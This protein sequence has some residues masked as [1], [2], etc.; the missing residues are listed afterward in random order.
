ML[1][2]TQKPGFFFGFFAGDRYYEKIDKIAML[3]TFIKFRASLITDK[4]KSGSFHPQIICQVAQEIAHLRRIKPEWRWLIGHGSGSFGHVVAKK[5]GTIDGVFTAEQ[6][7]GFAEVSVMAKRLNHLVVE[8]LSEFTLPIFGVQPS[9][10]AL[11]ENGQIIKMETEPILTAL[12]HRLIPLVYGDVALDK[13]LESTII[14]TEKIFAYL[15]QDLKP[16]RIFLLG[17]VAGISDRT[18]QI[19]EKITPD[20][21]EAIAPELR[22]YN[23][24]DV[25]GG[26]ADKVAK[27]LD[28][29]QKLPNL[30]IRIFS[31]KVPGELEAAL[32]G[33]NNSGTLIRRK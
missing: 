31:G 25:T 12:K 32:L 10:S 27:M 1:K 30:E 23:G 4:R 18:G 20:N 5:Y 7:Q 28:L 13:R 26:M 16:Q 19:I 22:G 33:Y 14:Y 2:L 3:L 17:Q 9:G 24:T 6:W 11:C 29:V 21:F 8:T 15:A